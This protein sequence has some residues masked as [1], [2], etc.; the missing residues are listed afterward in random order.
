MTCKDA[1]GNQIVVRTVPLME[2]GSLVT[3]DRYIGKTIDVKGLIDVY[4]GEYQ[5]KVFWVGNIII[6]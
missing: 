5:V 3:Q 6:H 4:D 1:N 2:N